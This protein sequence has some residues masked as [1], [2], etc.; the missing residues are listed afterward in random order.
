M[1]CDRPMFEANR[2]VKLKA[3]ARV[4]DEKV[5]RARNL[6][7]QLLGPASRMLLRFP[8]HEIENVMSPKNLEQ[9][10]DNLCGSIHRG[11]DANRSY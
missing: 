1:I 10:D 7:G 8:K 2:Y 6:A 4:L 9:H 11:S 5:F 3:T